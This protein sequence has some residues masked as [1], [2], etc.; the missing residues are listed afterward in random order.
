M[1]PPST[2]EL[3]SPPRRR[4]HGRPSFMLSGV[5]L[6]GLKLE[7]LPVAWMSSSTS[8]TLRSGGS[9]KGLGLGGHSAR[10]RL[11]LTAGD[12][13][14]Q[15]QKDAQAP[16][17][18]EGCVA[19]TEGG[20]GCGDCSGSRHTLASSPSRLIVERLAMNGDQ[21]GLL[22]LV[23]SGVGVITSWLKAESGQP[24]AADMAHSIKQAGSSTTSKA[25]ALWPTAWTGPHTSGYDMM[26]R[27]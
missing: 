12:G 9:L 1:T 5:G 24:T 26:V 15:A 6:E 18:G 8:L 22:A 10:K 23:L 25:M 3:A 27:C 11:L 13:D 7:G 19:G 14:L 21:D 4:L 17:G 2:D 16:E 20:E